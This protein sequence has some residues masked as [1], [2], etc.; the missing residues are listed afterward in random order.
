VASIARKPLSIALEEIAAG[1]VVAYWPSEDDPAEE[2]ETSA[3][4]AGSA[5]APGEAG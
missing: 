1:K 3:D 4:D 5:P 2:G